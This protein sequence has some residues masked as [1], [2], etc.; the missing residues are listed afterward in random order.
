MFRIIVLYI[1]TCFLLKLKCKLNVI[2][3]IDKNS[4]PGVLYIFNFLQKSFHHLSQ[5]LSM[6]LKVFHTR[7]A[8]SLNHGRLQLKEKMTQ[9]LDLQV[10]ISD[11]SILKLF[12]CPNFLIHSLFGDFLYKCT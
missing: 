3:Q 12:S 11:S 1:I 2:I 10:I 9:K 5:N 7:K 4:Y 6:W 8:G